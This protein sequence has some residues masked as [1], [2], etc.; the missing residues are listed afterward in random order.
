[1]SA[2]TCLGRG[3]RPRLH[4]ASSCAGR[5]RA[6]F[7]IRRRGEAPAR[8]PRAVAALST[9]HGGGLRPRAVRKFAGI[10]IHDVSDGPA[11]LHLPAPR[12]AHVAP[13]VPSPAAPA[14]RR[15]AARL[16]STARRLARCPTGSGEHRIDAD[17]RLRT[18]C[19]PRSP[20]P[21]CGSA[22]A[23]ARVRPAVG[24][25]AVDSGCL[26]GPSPPPS[27]D[28]GHGDPFGGWGAEHREG[29]RRGGGD[30][31]LAARSAACLGTQCVRREAPPRG[32]AHHRQARRGSARCS[33]D[34]PDDRRRRCL[35]GGD[36][37]AHHRPN[38]DPG[39]FPAD[40][41]LRP[42]SVPGNAGLAPDRHRAHRAG[43]ASRVRVPDFPP[44]DLERWP[45]GPACAP[46]GAHASSRRTETTA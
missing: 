42:R 20:Q 39:R 8:A 31:V 22:G 4:R 11:C 6:R 41:R 16:A 34:G 36:T 24:A 9:G 5:R 38:P 40:L 32:R 37:C 27:M 23:C 46:A 30:R 17:A 43:R 45:S 15:P 12:H 44:A 1:M 29:P 26:S 19:G 21:A 10:S 2:A 28:G 3:R 33:H 14:A 18:P 13:A 7:G 25:G 35:L